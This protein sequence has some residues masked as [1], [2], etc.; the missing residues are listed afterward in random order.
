FNRDAGKQIPRNVPPSFLASAGSGDREH[1]VWATEY[2]IPMLKK[3][4]P[5]VEMHIYG[6]GVHAGGVTDRGGIP[7]GTWTDRYF[8]WLKDLGFLSKPGVPTKAAA[9]VARHAG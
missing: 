4:V 2:F 8:D 3:G 9:D 7:F 6:N 5:N 1:A